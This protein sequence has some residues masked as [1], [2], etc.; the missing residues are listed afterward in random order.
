MDDI[1]PWLLAGDPAIRWVVHRDLLDSPYQVV[2]QERARIAVEGWGA[3]LLA[4]QAPTGRWAADQGP[5][6]YRSLYIP[7]W[8]ST[9]Y[10]LLLLTR[11]GLSPDHPPGRAGCRALVEGARWLPTGG[12]A[13]WQV[14]RE[15]L[16][17]DA[18]VLSIMEY[19][20]DPSRDLRDGLRRRIL[21][22]QFAD[23]GW[24]CRQGA[25]HSSFN[26]TIAAL[27]A[28]QPR[29]LDP[30]L[31]AAVHAGREFLLA[32]RLFRSHRTGVVVSSAF[33]RLRIPVGWQ[34]DVLRALDH[35][36]EAGAA[37]DHRLDDALHLIERRRG[38]DGRWMG[39]RP[40]P[41]ALH[42]ELEGRDAPSRWVTVR[43]LRTLRAFALPPPTTD[44]FGG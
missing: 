29:A 22:A 18:M 32:H 27:E 38:A 5:A 3:R 17:V 39:A 26:T 11:L 44:G 30:E 36:V 35:F 1:L 37:Y 31:A 19:F 41:G 6:A 42:F 8:T 33:T 14:P 21:A 25:T 2:E 10:T 28:L 9:T 23:G 13:L 43:C 34:Y 40:Q 16:C 7:K 24:N 15:D 12:V 4:R 20:D